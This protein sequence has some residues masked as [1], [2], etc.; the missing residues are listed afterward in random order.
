MLRLCLEG[1]VGQSEVFSFVRLNPL[2]VMHSNY[3]ILMTIKLLIRN[4]KELDVAI[5]I[6]SFFLSPARTSN[7]FAFDSA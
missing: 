1:E 2:H 3:A 6:H 7:D 4:K 5:V